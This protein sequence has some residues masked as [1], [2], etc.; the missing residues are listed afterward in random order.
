MGDKNSPDMSDDIKW[1]IITLSIYLSTAIIALDFAKYYSQFFA[2]YID[3]VN[4]GS[5]VYFQPNL[6]KILSDL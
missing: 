2:P 5:I 4:W 3:S 6:Q 1:E